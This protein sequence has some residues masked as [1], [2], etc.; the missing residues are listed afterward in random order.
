MFTLNAR[1]GGPSG[2]GEARERG[3][4]VTIIMA[5]QIYRGQYLIDTGK[6]VTSTNVGS[7]N[8]YAG[9][10]SASVT[11]RSTTNTYIPGSGNGQLLATSQSGDA[12]RCE[13]QY[14]RGGGFGVC[15][16]NAGK[17]FDLLIRN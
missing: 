1:D 16:N 9:S 8:A 17:E 12:L 11:G 15:R 10:T 6:T 5:G 14:V 2:E 7:A 3:R 13:F 4:E